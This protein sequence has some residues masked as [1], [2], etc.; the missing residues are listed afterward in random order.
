MLNALLGDDPSLEPLKRVLVDRGN[1]FFLEETMRTLVETE[2]LAGERGRYRLTQ[3][4]QPV[5]IPA[6][7]QVMLAARIDRLP[8]E[9]KHLLEMAS[10][11]GV[12]V[13]FALLQA[14]AELPDEALRRGLDHLRTAEF[15]DETGLSPDLDYSFKH[16]L[17]HEVAYSS[18]LQERLRKM[19]ARIVEAIETLYHDRLAEQIERLAHHAVRGEL[20]EKAVYYLRQSGLKASARSVLPEA[21]AR[22]EEALG[23]LET[24]PE[25][26]S[27]LE[28]AFDIRLELRLVLGWLGELQLVLARL[29]E[30]EA[31]VE[32][33]NDEGRRGRAFAFMTNTHSQLGELDEALASGSRAL[34]IARRLG[35][36]RLRILTT[37]FLEQAHF[38]RGDYERAIE[39]A[40][41]NLAARPADWVYGN[42]GGTAVPPSV[43]DR[44]WLVSS[45]TQLGRFGEAA[46]HE[47]EMI[48]L[49]EATQ[50]AHTVGMAYGAASSLHLQ[51]GDWAQAR[52]LIEHAIAVLRTANLV[53]LLGALA[54][55]AWVLAQH[56]ES[57]EALN[58]LREAE[59]LVEHLAARG[60]M[61]GS[62]G[63][64]RSLGRACLLLGRLDEA[65]SLADRGVEVNQ[66]QPG[67]AAHALHL[68]GDIATHPDRF[69]A[70]RG[71]AHY[72][73]ALALAEP[74][75][76]RP[77]VAHCHLGLGMLYRR[78]GKRTPAYE[79][80]TTATTMYREMDMR[81][82]LEQAK[83]EAQA[84][85]L[86]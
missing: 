67:F 64:Y 15:L 56:G 69:D 8:P 43:Y 11:I 44:H 80:I 33:L 78:T 3:P 7:V 53:N 24:L 86:T 84:S 14:I 26:Q 20:K 48:R 62:R 68:L 36:L 6:T 63:A 58:R 75:G 72:R 23:I 19:H 77:L 74:R 82:W 45:L 76:M 25:N 39:L 41:K 13:P 54:S 61:G 59:Q 52:P 65:R 18:V 83:T 49:A 32:R 28:Q 35:D 1:P 81:F 46:Q 5:Q 16:A 73:Q 22:F 34:E 21:R 47:A 60:V 71:E 2:A 57:N 27:S 30:A 38:F 55:S 17:T 79:H 40:T 12:D 37:S 51:R 70:E 50:H 66:S 85:E 4:L 9:D 31:L 42:W 29:R 10:I